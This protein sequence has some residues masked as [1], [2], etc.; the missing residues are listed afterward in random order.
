MSPPSDI[1]AFRAAAIR[2]PAVAIVAAA[3]A[4]RRWRVVLGMTAVGA[5]VGA[6]APLAI[7]VV[8]PSITI[9][10]LAVPPTLEGGGLTGPVLARR[11]VVEARAS[12]RADRIALREMTGGIAAEYDETGAASPIDQLRPEGEVADAATI[13]RTLRGWIGLPSRAIAGHVEIVTG[14]DA[15]PALRLRLWTGAGPLLSSDPVPADATDRLVATGAAT[16]LRAVD[17]YRHGLHLLADNRRRGG[18]ESRALADAIDQAVAALL[19]RGGKRD[20]S[21]AFVL[22]G[23]ALLEAGRARDAA[24]KFARAIE[25][26]SCDAVALVDLGLLHERGALDGKVDRRRAENLY[27][28]G[29]DCG[30]S[31]AMFRLGAFFAAGGPAG[32]PAEARRWLT[33]AAERGEPAAMVWLA[34]LVVDPSRDPAAA[35]QALAWLRRGADAGDARALDRLGGLYES[36]VIVAR[37]PDEAYR[38]YRRAAASGTPSGLMALAGAHARGVGVEADWREAARLNVRAAELGAVEGLA[39]AAGLFQQHGSAAEQADAAALLTVAIERLP[40]SDG[41]RR[42]LLID[43]LTQLDAGLDDSRREAAEQIANELRGALA[44][45]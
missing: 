27:R 40:P 38:L 29:T 2:L 21:R 3:W 7:E 44:K 9:L 15:R 14:A 17:P 23:L 12:L 41:S 4:S 16:L 37:D 26:D 31:L 1:P 11:L 35:T 6:L 36:G 18:S 43:R 25:R 34:D 20:A 28:A 30:S 39:H 8:S 10:S 24:G 45:R 33:R 5:V 19:A 22:E 32:D 13:A 42:G